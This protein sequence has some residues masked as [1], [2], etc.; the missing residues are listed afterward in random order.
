MAPER[1]SN[2]HTDLGQFSSESFQTETS[3]NAYGVRSDVWS[4]GIS[5]TEIANGRYPFNNTTPDGHMKSR[6]NQI[7]TILQ[8]RPEPVQGNYSDNMKDFITACLQPINL[9]PSFDRLGKHAFFNKNWN[10]ENLQ[11]YFNDVFSFYASPN[12][13][14]S[15]DISCL[16]GGNSMNDK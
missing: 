4:L 16:S 15:S 14:S 10:Q 2:T 5:L 1:I 3:Y 13:E 11:S 12:I 6:F 8:D 7:L 9:R